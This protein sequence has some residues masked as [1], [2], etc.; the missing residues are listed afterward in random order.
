MK[1]H[2]T[3]IFDEEMGDEEREK[4]WN[5]ILNQIRFAFEFFYIDNFYDRKAKRLEAKIKRRYG[6]WT[7]KTEANKCDGFLDFEPFYYNPTLYNE[8]QKKA[9]AGMELFGEYFLNL[10]D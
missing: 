7:E 5:D 2:G 4:K 3:P 6:D 9:L 1:K 8:I 10:W